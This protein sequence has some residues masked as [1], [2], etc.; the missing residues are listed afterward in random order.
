MHSNNRHARLFCFIGVVSLAGAS[1]FLSCGQIIPIYK[2]DSS[3]IVTKIES[4][5]ADKIDGSARKLEETNKFG[6]E[7]FS[8]WREFRYLFRVNKNITFSCI[9]PGNN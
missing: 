7:L 3:A 8:L 4:H 1:L 5:F 6:K 2:N 9:M